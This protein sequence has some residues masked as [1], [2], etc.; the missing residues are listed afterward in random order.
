M[1]GVVIGVHLG[2]QDLE[3]ATSLAIGDNLQVP[4]G[5]GAI[6][7]VVH[8]EEGT[9]DLMKVFAHPLHGMD[10]AE[11]WAKEES[12]IAVPVFSPIFTV[13][14]PLHYLSPDGGSKEGESTHEILPPVGDNSISQGVIDHRSCDADDG[15]RGEGGVTIGL[16]QLEAHHPT[17]A[18]AQHKKLVILASQ[19]LIGTTE[20]VKPLGEGGLFKDL[21][22]GS[23]SWKQRCIHIHTRLIKALTAIG[24]DR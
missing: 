3:G 14:H 17:H 6:A 2:L 1:T 19:S 16:P 23:E 9:G 5:D 12:S 22:V 4:K 7:L 18:D 10:K 24:V 20:V 13:G 15:I 11:V 21:G 8:D